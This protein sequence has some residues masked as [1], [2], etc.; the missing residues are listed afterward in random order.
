MILP[1]RTLK[2]L[3]TSPDVKQVQ[4]ALN[5]LGFN[6][7]T[8][9]SY[10]PGTKAAVLAFQKRYSSLTNDGSYGPNTRV[11]MEK[12]LNDI[13]ANRSNTRSSDNSSDNLPNRTLGYL[14]NST[15][16]KQVQLALNKLGFNISTDGSYG[17]GTKAAVLAFQKRY[18]SLSNDGIYGPST[19]A[20]MI[21]ALSGKDSS[22]DP[23]VNPS[24]PSNTKIQTRG[25]AF[26]TGK[27]S[28]QIRL[29]KDFF[30]SRGDSNVPQGYDYD[31][32]TKELV[33]SYQRSKGLE[34]DGL[35]GNL[36]IASINKEI[37][38]RRLKI[39]LI[40]PH[41]NKS[42]DMIII[43][44]SSN[45]LYLFKNGVIKET[46]P[47]ASGKTPALTPNGQ[48]TIVNKLKNPAWGGAVKYTPIAGGAPNNPL[49]SRW[50]GI[51]YGGGGTYGVHGNAQPSS[52]G[53]YASLGCVRMFIKDVEE[54]FTKIS[55][56]TPI[57]IGHEA[58]L[59]NSGVQFK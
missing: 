22:S 8:D 43:N 41:I 55:I 3:E 46:Y 51:S 45:T 9:S 32:R 18:A 19:R 52:I 29:L 5:K 47:V 16:V 2:Y 42:G 56:N 25:L 48:F 23:V 15:D 17:P 27:S 21:K 6:I 10:G 24:S 13:E 12:A 7:S 11:V 33:K 53:T 44:K 34:V 37:S 28:D 59:K 58:S 35:A 4:I 38:D 57:W 40:T 36:T 39:G 54:L 20:V 1:N 50:M 14:E 49:G 26:N 30:R 31:S